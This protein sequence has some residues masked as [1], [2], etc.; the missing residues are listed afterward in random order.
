M[1]TAGRMFKC[2]K[3]GTGLAVAIKHLKQ[4]K[5]RTETSPSVPFNFFFSRDKGKNVYLCVVVPLFEIQVWITNPNF[6]QA[7]FSGEVTISMS[8]FLQKQNI[9]VQLQLDE[10]S[11]LVQYR[12]KSIGVHLHL[13]LHLLS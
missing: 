2:L 3:C 5:H 1:N 8:L 6:W 13:H 9:S 12:G 10:S 7:G 11:G 4:P